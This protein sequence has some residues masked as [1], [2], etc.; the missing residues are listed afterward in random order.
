MKP[1]DYEI[2]I[3]PLSEEDGVLRQAQDERK[4]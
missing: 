3:R 2:V 1:Q 4:V